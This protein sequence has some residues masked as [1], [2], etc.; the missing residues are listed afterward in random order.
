MK[1]QVPVTVSYDLF[2]L[3]NVHLC[4]EQLAP[5]CHLIGFEFNIQSTLFYTYA[6][7]IKEAY[8]NAAKINICK[9]ELLYSVKHITFILFTVNVIQGSFLYYFFVTILQLESKIERLLKKLA[10]YGADDYIIVND[11]R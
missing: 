8:C 11:K 6:K 5:C 3:P 9:L 10:I 1:C 2:A 7:T 4:I